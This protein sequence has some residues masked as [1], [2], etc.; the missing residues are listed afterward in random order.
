MTN[1]CHMNGDKRPKT[2]CHIPH[3]RNI[4]VVLWGSAIILIAAYGSHY[5]VPEKLA[6]LPS[7]LTF[8]HS[9]VELLNKMWWG[10]LLGIIS[11]GLLNR[12]PRDFV[13]CAL[14]REGTYSGICRAIFA[15]MLLDLC[16]HGILMIG[17]K[18]YERGASIGQVVAFLI[19]SPWNSFSLTLILWSLVGFQWMI[20]FLLLSALIALSCGLT[21]DYL[22]RH[23]SLPQNPHRSAFPENFRFWHELRLYL[24]NRKI[25][26]ASIFTVMKEGLMGSGMVL[27]WIFF[28]VVLA[29]LIRMLVSPEIFSAYFGPTVLG[30]LF[31]IF[32]ATVIE[33][34]SEGS[35]PIATDLLTRA[36]A[37]GNSFAFLMTGVATDYT[38]ILVL[39]DA[40]ASWKIA[41]FLPLVTVPQVIMV[42]WLLNQAGL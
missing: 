12:I 25:T 35:L 32:V 26:P 9:V 4:D 14:G 19:A 33:V 8:S 30:L 17:A 3:F 7:L 11:V 13:L 24:K 20:S 42:A 2:A 29:A 31:T 1:A 21:F 27:R 23:G 39:K 22:M 34:C 37:P 36:S 6:S 38:E 5:L 41:F 18:L 28:G 40:T 10:I 15:G 16:S